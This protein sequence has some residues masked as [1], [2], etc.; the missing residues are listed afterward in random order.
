MQVKEYDKAKAIEYAKKWA[1]SRNTKFYDYE[2]LGGDCTNFISQC[3]YAGTNTMNYSNIN[4]WYYNNANAKSPSWTGVEF[5]Y[6]FLTT[7]KTV[8]PFGNE[9]NKI[10]I[11]NG[12]IVQLSFDGIKFAHSL[13]IVNRIND[14]IFV[15]T[16]TFDAFNR[17]L[18]T[19]HYSKLRYI[20]IK[21][22][23]DW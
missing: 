11:D 19:Y 17:D 15:A 10:E 20:K 9:V 2:N 4:G 14:K 8:G 7:N 22:Y 3:I 21:G 16:H 12:D 5:L 23:R 6:K 18:D 1:Y 13:F